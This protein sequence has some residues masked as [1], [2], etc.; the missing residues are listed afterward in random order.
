[1]NNENNKNNPAE[2]E[3][4]TK[5]KETE[6]AE[7]IKEEEIQEE[8]TLSAEKTEESEDKKKKKKN[9]KSFKEYIKSPK[10]K[11]GSMATAFTAGFIVV[12]ILINVVISS[13]TTRFPSMNIDLTQNK[14]NTLSDQSA[15]VVGAVKN[16]TNIY[17]IG[18]E[19]QI[20]SDSNYS[21]VAAL[22]AKMSE[23]NTRIKVS[24]VDIDKNPAFA[25]ANSVDKLA[26]GDVLVKTEKRNRILTNTDLFSQ[27]Q[28]STTGANLL[29]SQVDS[30]LTSAVRQVN[31]DT[32]PIVAF[33]TGHSP[34][35]DSTGLK[36]LLNNNNFEAKDFNSLTDAV[37][38]NA[39]LLV[40]P[41][42]TT[43]YTD[44]E[45]KKMDTFLSNTKVAGSRSLVIT[46]DPSQKA[47]PKLS[48]FLKEWGIAVKT[49]TVIAETDSTKVVSNNASYILTQIGTK[50]SLGGK[51]DYGY[52][53]MPQS[54][55]VDQL[56]ES[57]GSITTYPLATSNE[58]SFLANDKT[59]DTSNV[60]KA[61]YNTAVL[62]Q[63]SMT[64]N[65]KSYKANV[66]VFGS[67]LMMSSNVLSA[68]AFGNANYT[69]DLMKYG[70]GTTNNDTGITTNPVQTN[71]SDIKINSAAANIVGVGVFTILIPVCVLVAGI[72]VYLR[73]R[74]L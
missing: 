6:P 45:L 55:P 29:Y 11:H 25:S 40:L 51:S 18:V 32:V 56:F 38:S 31:S 52:V 22:A 63:K 28:D 50:L 34:A 70:T 36:T 43:D 74:H 14:T 41:T 4:A 2:N 64:V 67:S 15:K 1:M 7:D 30:A 48:N 69:L 62:A 21:Q 61:S 17:I 16:D 26:G 19:S 54:S 66:I 47:M 53:T 9:R 37:P 46:F 60:K 12:V 24:Y 65:E 59:T 39:Q 72:F 71:V 5:V 33:E 44:A 73:R 13:L 49:A 8:E 42:P 58:T 3:E 20:K 27:Q 23:K 68:S 10:F 57:Q 35:L